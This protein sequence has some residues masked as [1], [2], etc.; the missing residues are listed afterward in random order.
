MLPRPLRGLLAALLAL[1]VGACAHGP[2]APR[3]DDFFDDARFAPPPTPVDGSALF[4]LSDEMRRFVAR[5]LV[6]GTA[7]PRRVLV[8]ALY[9]RKLRIEYD[10]TLTRTAAQA[11]DERSGNCLSLVAMTAALA[12]SMG[13][14][15]RYQSVVVDSSWSRSGDLMLANGHINVSLGRKLGRGPSVDDRD[16]LL[17]DF[18]PPEDLRGARTRAIGEATVVAMYLNNRAAEL[19]VD[20]ELDLAYWHAREAMRRDPAFL[21]AHNTL[22]VVYL[23]RDLPASAERVLRAVLERD[24]RHTVAMANLVP[25]LQ[26]QGRH[27]EAAVWT[28]RLARAESHPPLHFLALGRAAMRDGDHRQAKRWFERELARDATYHEVHFWLA[29]AHQALGE[30]EQARRQLALALENSHTRTTRAMYE[31]K[32][33]RLKSAARPAAAPAPGG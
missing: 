31:S 26:R 32:L 6:L 20:G 33:A 21:A 3:L 30:H 24:P 2:A 7:D 11:F 22:A 14:P 13:L 27:D 4:A 5:E 16:E 25:A 19:M 12:K 15:V 9:G 1:L 17:V 10:S 28:E 29:A 18:L 8:D 23:R